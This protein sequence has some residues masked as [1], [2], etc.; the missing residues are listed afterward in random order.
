[1]C[2]TRSRCCDS[3]ILVNRMALSDIPDD[4]ISATAGDLLRARVLG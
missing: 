2:K 3:Y 1:M 4:V